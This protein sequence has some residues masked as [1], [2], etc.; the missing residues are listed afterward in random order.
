MAEV[1]SFQ[2][3]EFCWFELATSDQN[4]AKQFYS[5]LFDWQINDQPMGPDQTYTMLEKNGK[6][7]GALYGM[8]QAR[9][10]AGVPPHW[11]TYIASANVDESARR[12]KELGA[13]IVQEPF[14]VM[15]VGRMATIKDPTGAVFSVWQAKQHKG[16]DVVDE[17]NA[18]CWYELNT[19]D[20]DAAKNF[21]G[22]LLGWQAG[23]SPEYTEWKN[24]EK[25]IGGMMKIQPEWG[26][27]PAAWTNYV[28]VENVDNTTSKA[29]QLGA[30]A[31]MGPADIPNTGRFAV[32]QDPQGAVF[33]VY[34][35]ARK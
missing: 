9:I 20:T 18:F 28:M 25:H 27:M 14:D 31:L 10:S 13:S 26:P 22:K 8:E 32:L 11:N 21:Y 24:G 16:A 4:S 7:V 2:P 3:G 5:K 33:A 34:E 19:H 35:P 17:T 12:A 30:Q 6:S 1:T 29:K 23:G 15:D